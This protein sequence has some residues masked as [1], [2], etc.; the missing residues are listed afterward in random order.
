MCKMSRIKP[1]IY[2]Y[3]IDP[4]A[5]NLPIDDATS[6]VIFFT[7]LLPFARHSALSVTASLSCL[8]VFVCQKGRHAPHPE[9]YHTILRTSL[10][11]STMFIYSPVCCCRCSP[12]QTLP[13][14]TCGLFLSICGHVSPPSLSETLSLSHFLCLLLSPWSLWCWKAVADWSQTA[15][16]QSLPASLFSAPAPWFMG[17]PLETLSGSIT[18]LRSGRS[19]FHA[20]ISDRYWDFL[21]PLDTC[22][23][24]HTRI[25]TQSRVYAHTVAG[26]RFCTRV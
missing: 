8:H 7:V 22:T 23:D 24:T 11:C 3:C 4:W 6:K 25:H 17:K 18:V 19:W 26:S 14:G 9:L 13:A 12:V 1:L 21:L 2:L 10:W 16:F 5:L 20:E 15:L